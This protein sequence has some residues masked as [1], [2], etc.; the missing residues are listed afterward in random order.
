[1]NHFNRYCNCTH[2]TYVCTVV[3]VRVS[4]SLFTYLLWMKSS[5]YIYIYIYIS[6]Y[7]SIYRLQIINWKYSIIF[8]PSALQLK[9]TT[10]YKQTNI[11]PMDT[12]L[13][14][15][16]LTHTHLHTHIIGFKENA[17]LQHFSVFSL[18]PCMP[19]DGYDGHVAYP[20]QVA[21][22]CMPIIMVHHHHH[23]HVDCI[24]QQYSVHDSHTL[25]YNVQLQRTLFVVLFFL[26]ECQVIWTDTAVLKNI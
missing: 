19:Y 23:Q 10:V 17:I 6:I 1:M 3:F 22:K 15:R 16:T 2:S 21:G 4:C 7:L 13:H 9:I 24:V 18:H 26:H 11:T 20:L 5:I 12:H 14:T 8:P 25:R